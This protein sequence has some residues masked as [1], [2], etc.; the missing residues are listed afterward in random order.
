MAAG[1]RFGADS[2]SLGGLQVVVFGPF[3]AVA[4][5]PLFRAE[6][7][8]R[9]GRRRDRR[10]D[11]RQGR[12]I[13][14]GAPGPRRV[15]SVLRIVVPTRSTDPIPRTVPYPIPPHPTPAH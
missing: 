4:G 9:Q 2:R 15:A 3:G 5:G 8:K 1:R 11:R 10:R 13:G 12:L 14:R 7:E 6:D